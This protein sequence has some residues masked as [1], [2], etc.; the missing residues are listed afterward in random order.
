MTKNIAIMDKAYAALQHLKLPG[1]SFS[2]I[3]L[4][5]TAAKHKRSLL[6]IVGTI[7]WE[8]GEAMQRHLMERR[9]GWN[10]HKKLGL[11]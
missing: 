10:T 2:E 5:L 7:T 11:P 9:K 6:E 3:I 4:R 1:E 8:E